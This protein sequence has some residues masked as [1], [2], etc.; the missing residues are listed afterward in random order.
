[1]DPVFPSS[2][3]PRMN[4]AA[5]RN[6]ALRLTAMHR[7]NSSIGAS[8]AV[9]A[10]P[11]MPALL[12]STSGR[13]SSRRI[14]EKDSC[15]ASAS[16]TSQASARAVPPASRTAAAVAVALAGSMSSAAT[17]AP[18]RANAIAVA[19]P[20]PPPAPVITAV[21]PVSSPM[22]SSL[23]LDRGGGLRRKRP[24]EDSELLYMEFAG[25]ADH[26]ANLV[27]YG[28]RHDDP[29]LG[30][31]QEAGALCAGQPWGEDTFD[32]GHEQV[33]CRD[34]EKAA[35]ADDRHRHR[36]EVV[37]HTAVVD[38]GTG[39]PGKEILARVRDELA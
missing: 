29:I 38:V 4:S 16:L 2:R 28:V 13:P 5:H 30:V 22:A 11:T 26:I 27:S 23:F 24:A 14:R 37:I 39:G 12:K 20:I 10:G 19:A 17:A 33:R 3:R 6:M 21:R 36:H 15:T 34:P 32:G 31:E 8:S 35:V 18:S 1:M 25:G 7:S 9:P